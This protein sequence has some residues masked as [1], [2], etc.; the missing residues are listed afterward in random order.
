MNKLRKLVLAGVLGTALLFGACDNGTTNDNSSPD[1]P[2]GPDVP[3]NGTLESGWSPWGEITWSA[4]NTCP[5]VA[6]MQVVSAGITSARSSSMGMCASKGCDNSEV[7]MNDTEAAYL[8][9]L[10]QSWNNRDVNERGGHNVQSTNLG[11]LPEFQ[12]YDAFPCTTIEDRT[13]AQ[14]A[15][16]DLIMSR[17]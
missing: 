4:D 2:G 15:A 8:A 9:A 11:N 3:G 5:T 1:A 7:H 12:G 6:C 13:A 16:T 17:H 14:Q 10:W